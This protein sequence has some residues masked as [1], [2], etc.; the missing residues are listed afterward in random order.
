MQRG[1]E[2][3][4]ISVK[5]LPSSGVARI[6]V[7]VVLLLLVL[8][9]CCVDTPSVRLSV[10]LSVRRYDLRVFNRATIFRQLILNIM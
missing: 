1:K 8:F 6:I 5:Q 3:S 10:C 7:K 2:E 4:A 9:C